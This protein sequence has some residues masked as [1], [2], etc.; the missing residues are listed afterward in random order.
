MENRQIE[1]SATY[2]ELSGISSAFSFAIKVGPKGFWLIDEGDEGIE[3]YDDQ[4]ETRESDGV[5]VL[6]YLTQINHWD[7]IHILPASTMVLKKANL[8]SLAKVIKLIRS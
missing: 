6:K 2:V 3:Y 1:I 4:F 5:T 8:K 7:R